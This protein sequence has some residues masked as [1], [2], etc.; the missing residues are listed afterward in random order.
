LFGDI[1][2]VLILI[3]FSSFALIKTLN[4]RA[5]LRAQTS[6]WGIFEIS[7]SAKKQFLLYFAVVANVLY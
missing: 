1:T 2:S 5:Y 3:F 7:R 4:P 6:P